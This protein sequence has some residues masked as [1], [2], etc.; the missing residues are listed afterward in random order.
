MSIREKL[1]QFLRRKGEKRKGTEGSEESTSKHTDEN[2]KAKVTSE[3]ISCS[4]VYFELI[5]RS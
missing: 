5:L 2:V 1:S 4:A 3:L